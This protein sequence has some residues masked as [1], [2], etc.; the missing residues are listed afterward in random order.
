MIEEYLPEECGAGHIISALLLESVPGIQVSRFGLIP[1]KTPGD[2]RLIVEVQE[3]LVSM[4][5]W[6]NAG[7]L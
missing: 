2:F 4:T 3:G 1:K 6:M 5:E 7:A